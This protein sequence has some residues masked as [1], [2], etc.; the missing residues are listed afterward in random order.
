MTMPEVSTYKII[1]YKRSKN[2]CFKYIKSDFKKGTELVYEL[3]HAKTPVISS[4]KNCL[5]TDILEL[6]T[7]SRVESKVTSSASVMGQRK[8]QTET[9][10]ARKS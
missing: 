2:I 6:P 5:P 9:T 4:C 7:D 8:I 10:A 3:F 1:I